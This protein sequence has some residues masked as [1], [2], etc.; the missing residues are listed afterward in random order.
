MKG[1]NKFET[2]FIVDDD[3]LSNWP[4]EYKEKIIVGNKQSNI[5]VATLWSTR[6]FVASAMDPSDYCLVANFYDSQNGIEPMLRNCLGNPNIRYILVVGNDRARSKKTLV[7][8]FEKEL[9]EN[10]LITDEQQVD[11]CEELPLDEINKVIRNIE[12]F[13]LTLEMKSVEDI[14][15]YK[16]KLYEYINK[17]KKLNAYD[18][19][20]VFP[21]AQI[22]AKTLPSNCVYRAEGSF[23]GEVWLKILKNINIFGK[24]TQT[25]QAESSTVKECIN[26]ISIINEEDPDDPRMFAYFRFGKNDIFK[27]YKSFTENYKPA[28]TAYT[29]GSRFFSNNQFDQIENMLYENCYTKRC[30]GTTWQSK[31][32]YSENPPCV[33]SAQPN[34]QGNK[35]FMTCYIRSNDMFRAWPLN[36]FGLRKIQKNLINR[37]NKRFNDDANKK[38]EEPAENMLEMG[39][40]TIIS[41]SAHIYKE[42]LKDVDKILEEYNEFKPN[43]NDVHGYYTISVSDNLIKM[44]HWTTCGTLLREFEG[45]SFND[46]A[47][48]LTQELG[49]NDMFH[50]FYIGKELG[51]AETCLLNNVPYTQDE[52]IVIPKSF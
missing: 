15:E 7:S 50:L 16:V 37:L 9:T 32:L 31:D 29:Y 8:L 19:P 27:Y 36:A 51:K 25:T 48:K 21:K 34:I 18:L 26:M 38:P 5:A 52:A 2:D 33:V 24:I 14:E 43:F 11:I 39:A 30:F 12:A 3:T 17:L 23:V 4:F 41:H 44:K 22:K 20:K 47:S 6:E 1:E 10:K 28:D 49:T 45:D 35:L 40:L 46:V 13:D 42:N